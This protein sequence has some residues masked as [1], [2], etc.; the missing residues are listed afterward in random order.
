MNDYQIVH[1]ATH[2]AF[3]PGPAENS[4]I[5]FG[6]GEHANLL[7]IDRWPITDVELVVLSACETAVGDVPLGDGKEILGFG[8]GMQTAG[9]D[10]TIA[11]LWS[12]DDGGTQLLMDGFYDALIR[13]GLPKAEAL[14]QAQLAFITSNV[15]R[16]GLVLPNGSTVELDTLRHPHYWAPFIII[17][18]GL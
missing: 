6:N 16:G 14:R 12:V 17:G 2:A 7:D 4:F 13:G 1:L 11:S 8:Y 18:N 15:Q 9:A 5:V 10:A 3:N